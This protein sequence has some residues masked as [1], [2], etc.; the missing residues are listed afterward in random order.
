MMIGADDA[1]LEQR[2]E[3]LDIVGVNLPAHIIVLGVLHGFMLVS[4]RIQVAISS[5]ISKNGGGL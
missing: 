1:P 4:Q 3:A 5:P 2:P